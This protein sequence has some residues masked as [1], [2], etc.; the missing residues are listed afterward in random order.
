MSKKHLLGAL[1]A[2]LA[3]SAV[4]FT[5]TS[6]A[7]PSSAKAD[8]PNNANLT[9]WYWGEDDAPG[10]TNWIK[11][12]VAVYE[13]AHPKVKITLSIQST[14]TLISAFTTAAQTKSGPDIATQ[15]ATLPVL[16][17]AWNGDSVPISD[18]VPAS[19][20]K[21]W[22]GTAENMSGGKLWAMP[23][24]LLGIPFVW[25]KAMFKKAGL[26]PN[27]GPKTWTQLLADAKKLKAA[28]YT[29]LGM[30]NK[31]GYGGSWFFSL[32]G[33][34]NLNSIDELK[35]AMI[36]KSDFADPKFSGFY[37]VL[38]NLKKS[39]YL[40][41]D[42][43]SITFTQGLQ[44][45]QQKKAAMAWGTDGNIAAASK[46]L[47]GE[48]AMGISSIPVWGKGKLATSYDTTQSSSAFI[49]SWSKHPKAAA[50]FLVFLH[51]PQVLKD[52]YT[53]TGVFPADKRFPASLV[54]DP[55]A[56]KQLAL[57]KSAVSVWPE[58]YVPPQVDGNADLAAGELITSGSG[59]PADAIKLWKDELSKWKSQHPDEF[60]NY[61]KWVTT[62]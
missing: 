13:K 27:V 24:Y 61:T 54:T 36:G 34:Q 52:W 51:S 57:D 5:S 2:T 37:Q 3:L 56:K 33:K 9:Y 44:L 7:R 53:A 50:Q 14:D 21:N 35:D 38:A 22:I 26:D 6:I 62:G 30:G 41:S 4:A 1:V 23:Q 58:N 28:G 48:K 11:K 45:F 17:P 19:E 40:P 60:K 31:D 43:A 29:P 59:T 10:A 47:G 15:W 46:A 42:V 16:T 18:Y 25:N 12:E 39:G 55:I 49:T 20:T 8:D 32:I